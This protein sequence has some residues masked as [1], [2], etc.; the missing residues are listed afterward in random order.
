MNMRTSCPRLLLIALVP[1]AAVVLAGCGGLIGDFTMATTKNVSMDTAHQRVGKTEA[2]QGKVFT[3]PS[4]KLVVDEA[5]DNAGPNATY[6]TNVRI[7]Q[8]VF[9]FWTQM[10]VEG[11]AWAPAS[12]ASRTDP[13]A[14][15]LYDVERTEDGVFLVSRADEAKRVKVFN[16]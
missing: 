4:L 11:E 15:D 16:P 6:L 13:Q 5:L 14:G 1:L 8:R 7:H 3:P 10:R 9:L 2:A 12:S